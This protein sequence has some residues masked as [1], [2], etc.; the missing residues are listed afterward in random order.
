MHAQHA[1]RRHGFHSTDIGFRPKEGK[2]LLRQD[3]SALSRHNGNQG[4]NDFPN[5]NWKKGQPQNGVLWP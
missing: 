3:G 1:R 2:P 4:T 5:W